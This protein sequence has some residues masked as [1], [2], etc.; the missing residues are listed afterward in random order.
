MK[1]LSPAVRS[2]PTVEYLPEPHR[3]KVLGDCEI[4][5]PERDVDA[6]KQM[7]VALK[8]GIRRFACIVALV[9]GRA[10]ALAVCLGS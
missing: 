1:S 6:R 9:Q 5:L 2:Q 3:S 10:T 7:R 4:E 8:E